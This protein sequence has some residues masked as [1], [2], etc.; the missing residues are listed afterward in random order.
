MNTVEGVAGSAPEISVAAL[1]AQGWGAHE[2]ITAVHSF[3][4]AETRAT[5][6]PGVTRTY[7]DEVAI[8]RVMDRFGIFEPE[9]T[10]RLAQEPRALAEGQQQG[11]ER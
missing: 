7:L 6:T 8:A 3:A 2:I 4:V 9:F 1:T 5:R 11:E 10:N